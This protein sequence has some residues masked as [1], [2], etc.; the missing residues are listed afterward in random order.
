MTTNVQVYVAFLLGIGLTLMLQRIIKEKRRLWKDS[1]TPLPT[2]EE[3]ELAIT[4]SVLMLCSVEDMTVRSRIADGLA[5]ADRRIQYLEKFAPVPD[6]LT[7][8]SSNQME[9][10]WELSYAQYLTVPRSVIQSMP[11]VWQDR[12]AVLL[13]EMDAEIPQWRPTEGSYWCRLRD[14]RGRL[15]HDRFMEYRHAPYLELRSL[16]KVEPGENTEV[17]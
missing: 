9:M 13:K 1:D 6:D 10:F 16:R 11:I 7:Q 8:G 17:F 15:V 14:N 12:L 3:T 2:Y 4:N 5:A